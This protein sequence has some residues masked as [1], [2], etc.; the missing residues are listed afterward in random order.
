MA[1]GVDI[2]L[3]GRLLGDEATVGTHSSVQKG[4]VASQPPSQDGSPLLSPQRQRAQ[5]PGKPPHGNPKPRDGLLVGSAEQ[6]KTF[7]LAFEDRCCKQDLGG[8]LQPEDSSLQ[9]ERMK[10]TVSFLCCNLREWRH[11]WQTIN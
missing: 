2:G 3:K 7:P 9:A 11:E 10:I 8:K 1:V 5:I 6:S 4:P